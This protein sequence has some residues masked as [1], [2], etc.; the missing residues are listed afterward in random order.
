MQVWMCTP[1]HPVYGI[2]HVS[3]TDELTRENWLQKA[4]VR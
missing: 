2:S 3:I 4:V 1:P